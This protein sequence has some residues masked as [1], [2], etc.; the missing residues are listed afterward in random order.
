MINGQKVESGWMSQIKGIVADRPN[1]IRGDRCDIL[2][3]E[4][5]GSWENSTKAFIQGDA[6]ISIQGETFGI[7]IGGGT[8]G[9][10]SSALEGLK[11]LKIM[12]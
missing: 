2:L 4:E 7:K 11:S 9:D 6:L 5:L 3:Y 8:G 1:K 12:A 10:S